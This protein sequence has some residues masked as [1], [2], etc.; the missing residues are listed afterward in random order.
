MAISLVHIP[1]P[2]TYL[3]A[4]YTVV[5]HWYLYLGVHGGPQI[6]LVWSSDDEITSSTQ[7]RIYGNEGTYTPV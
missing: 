5:A 7:W 3:P 1:L 6:N 4:G 2:Y